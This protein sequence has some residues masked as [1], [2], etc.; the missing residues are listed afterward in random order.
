VSDL[1]TP[2]EMARVIGA[3]IGKPELPWVEFS[4]EDALNGMKQ[5][6]LPEELAGLYTE[7]GR[8]FR[9]GSIPKH[10]KEQGSPVQGKIRLEAFA[11]T[12]ASRFAEV[13]LV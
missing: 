11:K 7:M 12:F 10:Y 6:G 8:G 2:A 4:D 9:N 13:S 5:A 3:E 1:K